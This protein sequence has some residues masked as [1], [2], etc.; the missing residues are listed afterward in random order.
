[1]ESV[2]TTLNGATSGQQIEPKADELFT[3]SETVVCVFG[4]VDPLRLDE[5]EIVAPV[6]LSLVD[7]PSAIYDPLVFGTG[8][9]RDMV[10]ALVDVVTI[11]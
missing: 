7:V 4:L 10:P 8:I 9:G 2:E 11:L 1:M 5:S 6:L 3:L